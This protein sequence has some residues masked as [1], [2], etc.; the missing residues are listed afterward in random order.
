MCSTLPP[1]AQAQDAPT[2]AVC[3]DSGPEFPEPADVLI[4]A[5]HDPSLYNIAVRWTEAAPDGSG[6]V[7]QGIRAVPED[8]SDSLDVY[9]TEA[10]HILDS[11]TLATFGIK[12]KDWD[13]IP[14]QTA[15]NRP[16]RPGAPP[17]TRPMRVRSIKALEPP[18]QVW[19]DSPDRGALAA[20]DIESG[21]DG[22]K[23]SVRMGIHVPLEETVA[24]D[25]TTATHGVW[26]TLDDGSRLWSVTLAANE[27]LGVRVHFAEARLPEGAQ[28]RIYN[29]ATPSEAYGPF[30][31][32]FQAQTDLWTPTCYGDRV[33]VECFLPSGADAQG[34]MVIVDRI[35]YQYRERSTYSIGKGAAGACNLDVTCHPDWADAASAVAGINF[36]GA[37]GSLDC[38]ASLVVD[39]DTATEIPYLVTAYHCINTQALATNLEAYWLY[40]TAACNGTPPGILSVPRTT[41]GADLLVSIETGAGT[42]L[43][44][45]RLRNSPSSGVGQLGWSSLPQHTGAQSI[46]IHHPQ[47]DFK[48]I[49]FGNLTDTSSGGVYTDPC[50]SVERLSADYYQSTWTDG[51][52]EPG[53]S[54]SPLLNA[55]RQMIGQLWGGFA[56]CSKPN[57]PDYYGR[58]EVSFPLLQGY[59]FP[60]EEA[61]TVGF[62]INPIT[63]IEGQG[64]VEVVVTLS[65]SLP[66]GLSATVDYSTADN[67][68]QEGLDYTA[69]SGTLPFES[70][71]TSQSFFV[72]LIDDD[73]IG[74]L[75][76]RSILLNLSNP[77][78]V[79][80]S[81]SSY[82]S[83]ILIMDDDA[84]PRIPSLVVPFFKRS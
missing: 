18:T 17:T 19:V 73:I 50:S 56:S 70:G 76:E 41:G 20:E 81:P 37:A 72:P 39:S 45:L 77:T 7:V 2:C 60:P 57:C 10:G 51:T 64:S 34:V 52:T 5:G 59:L 82:T 21:L 15:G 55:N 68:A 9:C 32:S 23:G 42:D 67:S 61:P 1:L 80:P 54:G 83:S 71:E 24:L 26:Q 27:A 28:L 65:E 36:I 3:E 46:C 25:E 47:G 79:E 8:G 29:E 4:D 62:Q 53:S 44:L 38:T 58:F 14:V 22:S 16:E 6:L 33:T 31:D 74:P 12:A 48:R 69:V 11:E 30:P 84:V 66:P 75:E 13:A 78:M 40:E 63:A 35:I 43:S 49:T